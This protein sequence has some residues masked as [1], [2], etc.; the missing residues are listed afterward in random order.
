VLCHSIISDLYAFNP[1]AICSIYFFD[2]FL[3]C[4]IVSDINAA[5]HV[6]RRKLLEQ[7]RF[8]IFIYVILQ[9]YLNALKN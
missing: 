1:C 9:L 2:D 4:V 6:M 3:W 5:C 8:L 7:N